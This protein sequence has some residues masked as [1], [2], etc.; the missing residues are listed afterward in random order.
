MKL[1]PDAGAASGIPFA[2][3]VA[4]IKLKPLGAAEVYYGSSVEASAAGYMKP[5]AEIEVDYGSSY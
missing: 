5:N 2:G 3:G 1:K 4:Y